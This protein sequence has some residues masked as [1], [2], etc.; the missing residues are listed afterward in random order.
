MT[1]GVVGVVVLLGGTGARAE[2]PPGDAAARRVWQEVDPESH[3][4]T[5]LGCSRAVPRMADAVRS[6]SDPMYRCYLAELDLECAAYMGDRF[7]EVL[8]D[9]SAMA[10]ECLASV[11]RSKDY[12]RGLRDAADQRLRDCGRIRVTGVPEGATLRVDGAD[13]GRLDPWVAPGERRVE[14]SAPGHVSHRT[15]VRV[16]QGSTLDLPVTLAAEPAPPAAVPERPVSPSA[17][18]RVEPPAPVTAGGDATLPP[19]RKAAEPPPW[20]RRPVEPLPAGL[21]AGGGLAMIVG[22]GVYIGALQDQHA[23]SLAY[24]RAGLVKTPEVTARFQ[25]MHDKEIAAAVLLGTGAAAMVGGVLVHVFAPDT[26]VGA[27]PSP[28]GIAVVGSF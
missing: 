5:A 18:P 15:T 9:A 2:V 3:P 20:F 6:A 26:P 19:V 11:Q 7:C 24:E 10:G 1:A 8:G 13:R 4:P 25:D 22:F 23:A 16:R 21:M 17:E 14:V 28:G 27:S 12:A